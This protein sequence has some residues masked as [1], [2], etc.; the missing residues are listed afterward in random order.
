MLFRSKDMEWDVFISYAS[1]DNDLV[2]APL[3][4]RL[5]GAGLRVWW[6]KFCLKVGDNLRQKID[7]GL[8]QSRYGIVILSSDFFAKHFTNLELDGLAQR[9]VDGQKV[10]LPIWNGLTVEDVRAYSP[11]LA[12]RIAARWEDGIDEV[13]R[14][15]V[16]VIQPSSEATSP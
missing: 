14:Q 15:L 4:S 7:E 13:V 16:D 3:V 11:S 1:E 6:D 9:E 12:G 2:A 5:E 10:I 8:R